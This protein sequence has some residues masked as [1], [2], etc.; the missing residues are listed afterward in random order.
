MIGFSIEVLF[1]TNIWVY[2]YTTV[3][4]ILRSIFPVKPTDNFLILGVSPEP[5][6]IPLY[7]G[8]CFLFVLLIYFIHSKIKKKHL[9]IHPWVKLSVFL[10]LLFL[11][12]RNLGG[13]PLK[14][15][16]PQYKAI[17]NQSL[18]NIYLLIYFAT[19]LTVALEIVILDKLLQNA[20]LKQLIIY[21][22]VTLFIVIVTFPPRF[23]ISGIDYSYF[24]GPVWEIIKGKTIYTEVSSQY[25]F[26]S[27]LILSL[28]NRLGLLP[29][30]Y[31]PVLIWVLFMVQYILCFYLI[32]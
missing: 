32:S 5:F 7:L 26:V 10:L 24:Y 6:E 3:L 12:L 18:V 29:L 22:G 28:L 21:T 25:G 2:I 20:K 16:A 27:I 17:T 14:D 1:F 15:E 31:L 4:Q 9:K 13:Y 30:L 8:L 23:V 19:M 11:F